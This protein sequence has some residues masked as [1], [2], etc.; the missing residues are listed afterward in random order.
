MSYYTPEILR[1]I[2]NVHKQGGDSFNAEW[3]IARLRAHAD[4]LETIA[5]LKEHAEAAR[6]I[7]ES[8]ANQHPRWEYD[9]VMQDP[10]GAHAWL[11]AYRADFPEDK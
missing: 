10:N 1:M 6:R 11:A 9:G 3:V 7:I 8:Y 2:A 4:A 5:K